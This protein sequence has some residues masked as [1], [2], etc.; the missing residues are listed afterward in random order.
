[1]ASTSI[2]IS[3]SDA[4]Q[5][6]I[7]DTV[8]HQE[9]RAIEGAILEAVKNGF[10]Q[11]TLSSGS[12]MTTNPTVNVAASSVDL[13]TDQIYIPNHPFK[14]GELVMVSSNG[15][16]PS[17]LQQ[18]NF[19]SAIFIDKDHIK[20]AISPA[21]A[22]ESRP[23]AIDFNVGVTGIQVTNSGSGYLSVP[24]ITVDPSPEG[25]TATAVAALLPYGSINNI[26]VVSKGSGYTNQPSVYIGPVGGGAGGTSASFKVVSVNIANGGTSYRVGDVLT[27][28]GGAGQSATVTVGRVSTSGAVLEAAVG[29][30]GLYTSLP[31]LSDADTTVQPAGGSGCT[32]NLSMGIARITLVSGGSGYVAPPVVEIIGD[33]TGA[34][35]RAIISAGVVTDFVIVN[36]GSG[37]TTAPIISLDT[38][39]GGNAVAVL[40]PTGIQSVILTNNGGD[41]YTSPPSVT[42]AS[43][44][45]GASVGTVTMKIVNAVIT[46]SG[47]GYSSGDTLLVA[48]GLGSLNATVLITKVG[49]F[50]E[51][52][53][54]A[55]AT[56]GEYTVLPVL[57]N[58]SVLGGSGRS[59][60]FN[61][62]AGVS[63]IELADAGNSYETLP[64][65]I[66]SPSDG[67]GSGAVAVTHYDYNNN[68]FDQIGSIEVL[69]SGYDYTAIPNVT[70]TNG[71]G[72]TAVAVLTE[73]GVN[74]IAVTQ[75]GSGYTYANVQIVG[76]GSNAVAT[77]TIVGG[78]I[79][80]ISVT[81]QGS[82]YTTVPSVVITG[83]GNGATATATLVPTSVDRIEITNAGSN[84][85]GSTVV[86]IDGDAQGYTTLK[87]TGVNRIDVLDGGA[88][89]VSTPTIYLIP[90]PENIG[91]PIQPALVTTLGYGI[92]NITVTDAGGGY[93]SPPS[94]NI[95]APLGSNPVTAEAISSI[96]IGTGTM[97]VSLYPNSRDYWSIWKNQPPSDSSYIRPYT[98][99]MDT[100]MS[101]FVSM[102][103]T[104]NR[105]T[106]P[107][108]GN[109]IQWQVL[110]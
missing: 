61:L 46:N 103:Y 87:S 21:A 10:Y 93:D 48:G 22:M 26:A 83:D 109:T 108:T 25:K 105:Q 24:N 6:P 69:N 98:E 77:A 33:G 12:P 84:Y 32:L 104:I 81:M 23:L 82:G 13:N 43:I 11:A 20:L 15:T 38:G 65:V 5:N 66:I 18:S 51:I 92:A 34:V 94:V 42:I 89:W 44:G 88:K 1:M 100:V 76:N 56:S 78:S 95:P 75:S 50:G 74:S 79:A 49:T 17:P 35:A 55:L 53:G 4:R 9:A 62:K 90:H 41:N 39:S 14:T 73:T 101:Y 71:T 59:A 99:R 28:I 29:L 30:S 110:W 86:S 106:N 54:Y 70:L 8:V 16:L 58:N 67:N 27:V 57:N 91:T 7:R 40:E 19:Y 107:V 97:V 64:A 102:G 96:G 85:N 31:S 2:F 52:L 47:L 45:D 80:S 68:P 37:Y 72:A 36:S 60:T 3:A 63:T